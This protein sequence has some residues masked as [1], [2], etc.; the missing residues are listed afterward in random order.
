MISTWS[1]LL[2]RRDLLRELVLTEL[3]AS[4][5]QTKLGWLWW[6]LDPI[7][8]MLIYWMIVVQLLGKGAGRYE[9]YWIF[10][11]FGLVT[12]KHVSTS[13]ARAANI[14]NAQK[15]LIRSVAFPTMVLPIASS[16]SS[17][18]F[19]LFGFATLL[20]MACVT[21]LPA[22][23]GS[24]LPL[25]Q[26]PPL[27]VLQALLTTALALPLACLGVVY[28]DFNGL[29]PHILRIAFYLSP[30]LYG[31]DLVYEKVTSSYG[32]GLGGLLYHGYMA[33]PFAVIMTGYREAV[34]YG[35]FLH[36]LYYLQLAGTAA[37]LFWLGFRI[38]QHYDRRV[39][40]FL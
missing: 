4:T 37:L 7:L 18:A 33:N 16:I 38:Y 9:P 24:W 17:F 25:V 27:M 29:V 23:S 21:P 14:L 15:G 30:G 28:R 1:N 10:V 22:H 32:P 31:A 5:A 6:L 40:K 19:F 36:P 11:Y 3:R 20:L 12:W 8:M 39:I 2:S 34:F 13:S 26:V 35:R